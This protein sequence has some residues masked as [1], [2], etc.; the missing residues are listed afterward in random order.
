MKQMPFEVLLHAQKA[1]V[2]SE[3]ANAVLGMWF[4]SIPHSDEKKDEACRVFAVMT[5]LRDG[6]KELHEAMTY[7]ERYKALHSGE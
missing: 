3:Q 1:L 7:F 2:A 5:L 4:D 6:I